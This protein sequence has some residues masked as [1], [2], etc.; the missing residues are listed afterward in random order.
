MLTIKLKCPKHPRYNPVVQR[1]NGIVGG[2]AYC[3][4][5]YWVVTSLADIE[6]LEESICSEDSDR[7]TKLL[8]FNPKLS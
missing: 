1:E 4:D 2:C 3:N 7:T 5:L 8:P 6:F